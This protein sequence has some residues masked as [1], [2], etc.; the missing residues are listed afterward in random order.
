MIVGANSI[1]LIARGYSSINQPSLII[2]SAS[3]R[4]ETIL[5]PSTIFPKNSR[6]ERLSL[7]P[8]FRRFETNQ[9]ILVIA[10]KFGQTFVRINLQR[11]RNSKPQKHTFVSL[12]GH[13]LTAR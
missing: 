3:I 9:R 6:R 12:F 10:L 4:G 8:L 13:H 1:A 5:T 7:F 11:Q 2:S